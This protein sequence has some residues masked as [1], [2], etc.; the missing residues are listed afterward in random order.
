LLP[1]ATSPHIF[2]IDE[3]GTLPNSLFGAHKYFVIGGL[4]IPY[5]VWHKIR[6]ALKGMKIRKEI[7]GELEWRFF[8]QVPSV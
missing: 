6:D 1:R 8:A 2:F 4:I 5:T 3:S 7:T